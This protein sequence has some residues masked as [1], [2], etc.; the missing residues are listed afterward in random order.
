MIKRI[1]NVR[2]K[3]VAK[4]GL[5]TPK[6][7]WAEA[8]MILLLRRGCY[9]LDCPNRDPSLDADATLTVSVADL[10]AFEKLKSNNRTTL[11]FDPEKQTVTLKAPKIKMPKIITPDKKIII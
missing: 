3:N 11:S 2:R 8:F 4:K 7:E 6:P 5:F 9:H 1:E 10:K